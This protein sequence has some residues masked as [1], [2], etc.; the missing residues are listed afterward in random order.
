MGMFVLPSF[1]TI[2]DAGKVVTNPNITQTNT[3]SYFTQPK[4]GSFLGTSH[5]FTQKQIVKY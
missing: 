1:S 3:V 4:Y 5:D 2:L